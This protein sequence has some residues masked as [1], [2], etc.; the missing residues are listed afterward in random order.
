M[1]WAN[2]PGYVRFACPRSGGLPTARSRPRILRI[3]LLFAPTE[4][5]KEEMI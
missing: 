3:S 1:P 5:K 4:K 2:L